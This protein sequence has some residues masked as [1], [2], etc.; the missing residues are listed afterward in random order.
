MPGW[1]VYWEVSHTG[2]GAALGG[3]T[4]WEVGAFDWEERATNVA[5]LKDH[6]DS[7][8]LKHSTPQLVVICGTSGARD[9]HSG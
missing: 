8:Q 9:S 1:C 6:G 3:C 4:G 7:R 5:L 2:E